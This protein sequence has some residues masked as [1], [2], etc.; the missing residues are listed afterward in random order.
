MSRP[1]VW[2]LRRLVIAPAVVV[3][4]VLMWITLPGWLLVATAA[5]GLD[6]LTLGEDTAFSL[7]FAPKRTQALV[8]GGTAVPA[9]SS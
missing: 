8:I 7:G 4:T 3:L 6:A 2:V 9:L 5:R 1:L